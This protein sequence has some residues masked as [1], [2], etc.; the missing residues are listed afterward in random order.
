M[1]TDPKAARHASSRERERERE[2]ERAC[3]VWFVGLLGVGQTR[4]VVAA[5]STYMYRYV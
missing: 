3:L 4:S 2:R 5:N 1:L